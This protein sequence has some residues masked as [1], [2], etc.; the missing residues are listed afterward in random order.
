M[1]KDDAKMTKDPINGEMSVARLDSEGTILNIV[2][3]QNYPVTISR[4]KLIGRNLKDLMP[5]AT[6]ATLITLIHK[7]LEYDSEIDTHYHMI[8]DGIDAGMRYARIV[9]IETGQVAVY[10]TAGIY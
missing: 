2:F 10:Q 3:T 7:S 1:T 9:P 6:A 8:L 4:E 5:N